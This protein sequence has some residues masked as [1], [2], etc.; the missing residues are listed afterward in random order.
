MANSLS[1]DMKKRALEKCADYPY[2]T[3]QDPGTVLTGTDGRKLVY[4]QDNERRGLWLEVA[5]P[6]EAGKPVSKIGV[7]SGPNSRQASSSSE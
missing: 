6:P 5:P 3:V 7:S 4:V 1:A 2:L